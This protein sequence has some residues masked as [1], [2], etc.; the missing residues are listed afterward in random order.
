MPNPYLIFLWLKKNESIPPS[1]SIDHSSQILLDYVTIEYKFG[2]SLTVTQ[3]MKLKVVGSPATIQRKIDELLAL[4][5]ITFT[6]RGGNMRKKFLTPSKVALLYY[7]Q[8]G[9]LFSEAMEYSKT[10]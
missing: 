10:W 7:D 3:A 5:L 4:D 1:H 9:N 8:L 2:N 6:R